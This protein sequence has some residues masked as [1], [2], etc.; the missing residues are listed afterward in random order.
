[1]TIIR[2]VSGLNPGRNT[3]CHEVLCSSTQFTREN[4]AILA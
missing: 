2:Q 3:D 1:M 4:A